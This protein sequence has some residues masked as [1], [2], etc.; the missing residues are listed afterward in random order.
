MCDPGRLDVFER[1]GFACVFGTDRPA[2]EPIAMK[3]PDFSNIARVVTNGDWLP[4]IG[5][6]S[7][8]DVAKPLEMNAVAPHNAGFCDHDQQQ[9]QIFQ[10]I[11][12]AG[13]PAIAQPA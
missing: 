10:A 4:H 8:V 12:H 6:E 5:G 2:E 11:W 1:D 13:Q 3:Y 9:I 7:R